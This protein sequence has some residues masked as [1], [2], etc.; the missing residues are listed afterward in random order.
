MSHLNDLADKE[1]CLLILK[2]VT[3]FQNAKIHFVKPRFCIIEKFLR[4]N[5]AQCKK[6]LNKM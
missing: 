6:Y 1:R 3:F 4:N 5:N 2:Y